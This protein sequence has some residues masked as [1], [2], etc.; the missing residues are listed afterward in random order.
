MS[1]N[2]LILNQDHYNH[3]NATLIEG[4]SKIKDEY[5]IKLYCNSPHNYSYAPNKH[6]YTIYDMSIFERL[7]DKCDIIVM[8]NN[9]VINSDSIDLKVLNEKGVYLDTNDYAENLSDPEH[10]PLYLKREY[11]LKDRYHENVFPFCFGAEDRYFYGGQN[12]LKIWE[13]KNSSLACMMGLGDHRPWRTIIQRGLSDK[14][15]KRE[16]MQIGSL[17]GDNDNS[18]I[19]TNDRNHGLFFEQLLDSKISVD[20]Y[21]AGKATNTG[22]FFESLACG[23]ALFYQPINIDFPDGFIDG[24]DIIIYKSMIDLLNKVDNYLSNPSLLKSIAEASFEKTKLFHTT[25]VRAEYF[26]KLCSMK[27]LIK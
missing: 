18:N 17:Y 12:F 20:S 19:I 15:W 7:W 16:D 9:F 1:T 10:F 27:G 6:D 13:E 14:Y 11:A 8:P 26:V 23:C 21:G 24:E 25:K 22:R 2:I 5:D 4:L 3:V